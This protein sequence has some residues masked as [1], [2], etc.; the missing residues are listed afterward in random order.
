MIYVEEC[1]MPLQDKQIDKIKPKS[2]LQNFQRGWSFYYWCFSFMF[3][4]PRLLSINLDKLAHKKNFSSLCLSRCSGRALITFPLLFFGKLFNQFTLPL[5]QIPAQIIL[6]V[7]HSNLL[8]Q[9]KR[10][11]VVKWEGYRYDAYAFHLKL[12]NFPPNP[13]HVGT[14]P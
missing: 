14:Q 5:C 2:L 11:S 12:H 1:Y 9:S 6:L 7:K 4:C 3:L 8:S 10:K 13:P